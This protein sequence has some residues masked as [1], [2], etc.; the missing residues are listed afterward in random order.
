MAECRGNR[1][2]FRINLF[3][4]IPD[5]KVARRYFLLAG[6]ERHLESETWFLATANGHGIS[7]HDSGSTGGSHRIPHLA[8]VD[9]THTRPVPAAHT[10]IAEFYWVGWAISSPAKLLEGERLGASPTSR[11]VARS[12]SI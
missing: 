12:E 6:R 7:R 5:R 10:P 9:A 2:P 4:C 8:A 1:K 3:P 11:S